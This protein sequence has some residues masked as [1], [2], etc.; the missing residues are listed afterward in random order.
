MIR[1]IFY[2]EC[3]LTWGEL[4]EMA[5]EILN[6][7]DEND[8]LESIGDLPEDQVRKDYKEA[9]DLGLKTFIFDV[10]NDW[11]RLELLHYGEKIYKKFDSI[12]I[13]KNVS[14]DLRSVFFTDCKELFDVFKDE[15]IKPSVEQF[16]FIIDNFDSDVVVGLYAFDIH[17]IDID[18]DFDDFDDE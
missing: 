15:D 1:L 4:K 5:L 12:D 2:K 11:G 10:L 7:F 3:N 14:D 17:Y 18:D 16:D 9:V 6:N 8:Y 13:E